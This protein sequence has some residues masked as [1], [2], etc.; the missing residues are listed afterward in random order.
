M[1]KYVNNRK[2]YSAAAVMIL[3]QWKVQFMEFSIC[4]GTTN[5]VAD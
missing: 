4:T 5:Y 3:G 1:G 2:Q